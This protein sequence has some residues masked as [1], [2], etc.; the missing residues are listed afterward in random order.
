MVATRR[1]DEQPCEI[2]SRTHWFLIFQ[3][4]SFEML[5]LFCVCWIEV[6][7]LFHLLRFPV[8]LFSFLSC[9]MFFVLF[10][11]LCICCPSRCCLFSFFFAIIIYLLFLVFFACP[12]FFV[13]LVSG[14]AT[15]YGAGHERI[16][17]P[18]CGWSRAALVE[19]PRPAR[20][21]GRTKKKRRA[22]HVHR[23]KNKTYINATDEWNE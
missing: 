15:R 7:S 9:L 10:S 23:F 8:L 3:K 2:V 1:T 12:S 22:A 20:G 19:G 17:R 21:A 5:C 13:S 14:W 11:C 18:V 4:S 16:A 6:F